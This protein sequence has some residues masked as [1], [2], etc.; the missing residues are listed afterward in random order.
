MVL[1]KETLNIN[2]VGIKNVPLLHDQIKNNGF[3][4]SR[5]KRLQLT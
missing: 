3:S 1:K 5:K 4:T 2:V